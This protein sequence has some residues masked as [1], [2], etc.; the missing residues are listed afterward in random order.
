MAIIFETDAGD[1]A[2]PY[3]NFEPCLGAR[4]MAWFWDGPAA[5][6]CETDNLQDT[7]E[8]PRPIG[9]PRTPD[10]D[11][12]LMDGPTCSKG[13]HRSEKD[14]L[15]KAT[16]QRWIKPLPRPKGGCGRVNDDYRNW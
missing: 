15:P 12:W 2:C 3:R 10:G 1:H 7:A 8:G 13:Y 9:G 4:C 11:G 6:R 5:E 14:K 16:S